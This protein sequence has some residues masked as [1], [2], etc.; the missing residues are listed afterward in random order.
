MSHAHT[1]DMPKGRI[2]RTKIPGVSPRWYIGEWIAAL[3]AMP[4]DICR[5]TLLTQSY[6]NDL[7]HQRK[8]NPSGHALALLADY[9]GIKVDDFRRP[10]PAQGIQRQIR[11]LSSEAIARLSSTENE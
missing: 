1:L 5:G 4:A 8:T 6:L 2:G 11:G 9:L 3:R 10:P 7:I